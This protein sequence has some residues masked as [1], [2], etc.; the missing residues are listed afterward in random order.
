M[1]GNNALKW[2]ERENW[3]LGEVVME[4]IT[5]LPNK[6]GPKVKGKIVNLPTVSSSSA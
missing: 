6:S 3:A 2:K 4:A 5:D 1:E